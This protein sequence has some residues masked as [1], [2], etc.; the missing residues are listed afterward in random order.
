MITRAGNFVQTMSLGI[1][2][3]EG[4]EES[5]NL[6]TIKKIKKLILLSENDPVINIDGEI[7]PITQISV[8]QVCPH[9]L[10]VYGEY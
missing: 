9:L 4:N 3:L 8:Y 5:S 6:I 7:L 1:K 2:Y 10:I